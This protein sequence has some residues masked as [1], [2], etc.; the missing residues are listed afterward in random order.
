MKVKGKLGFVAL[1]FW[2]W[3]PPSYSGVFGPSN[4][5]ECILEEVPGIQNDRAATMAAIKCN[6]EF[7][8]RESIEKRKPIFG[9]KTAPECVLKHGKGTVSPKAARFITAAC[10]KL[11]PSD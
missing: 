3:S 8:Y 10:H 7:S 9:V 5:A 2:F 6:K 11:Y 1:V 4:W